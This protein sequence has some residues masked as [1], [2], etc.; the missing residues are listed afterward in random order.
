[1]PI[2]RSDGLGG[3]AHFGELAVLDTL[4]TDSQIGVSVPHFEGPLDLLLHLIKENKINIYDIPIAQITQQYLE[5]LHW[6]KSV[7][8]SIAG[9]FLV[10]AAT[11]IL[12]KSKMLLPT[13]E[14]EEEE[15]DDDLGDP[16]QDLVERLIAYKKFKAAAED[17]ESLESHWRQ[18]FF[19]EATKPAS[20]TD[21][22]LMGDLTPFD[23]F[24]A[25]RK[26]IAQFP[27]KEG[28]TFEQDELSVRDQIRFIVSKLQ[29]SKT[30][31]FYELFEGQKTRFA[32]VVT[33]L[34]LLEVVRIGLIK[35]AQTDFCGPLRLIGTD[36][37]MPT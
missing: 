28:L 9:D 31:L 11:L 33:F 36:N 15:E 16:R 2:G 14:V 35:M 22:I 34:A 21:E 8:L 23:L 24:E 32:V 7:N 19:R 5:A 25:M 27:E 26:I 10:M 12:M 20:S 30:I 29:H 6:M 18:V 1:M 3:T 17:L 13:H 37:L 4:E